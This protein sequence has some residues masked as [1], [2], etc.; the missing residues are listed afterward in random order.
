M[1]AQEVRQRRFEKVVRLE[2][3]PKPDPW[4]LRFLCQALELDPHYLE[5]LLGVAEAND[6]MATLGV[7]SA[8]Y[9]EETR[10]AAQSVIA[11]D[12]ERAGAYC[13]L[14]KVAWQSD[15][16]YA[17]AEALFRRAAGI[18]PGNAETLIALSDYL[19]YQG[20]YDEALG[21]AERAGEEPHPLEVA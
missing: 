7:N 18:D 5:P 9:H 11:A 8:R 15:R 17:K 21:A 1:V 3:G 13:C 4:M 2:H 19:C 10:K 14:G 12:P 6:L 16:D 20:R